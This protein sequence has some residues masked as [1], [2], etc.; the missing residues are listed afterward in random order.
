MTDRID[1]ALDP[2]VLAT[3]IAV[4][5]LLNL[6]LGAVLYPY[7]RDRKTG[8]GEDERM[9]PS[10]DE[11]E[12]DD[13]RDLDERIDEFIEHAHKDKMESGRE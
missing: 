5:V 10:L 11:D 9:G 4:F 13:E 2:T 6:L 1:F 7:L 8:D 3:A 12:Q